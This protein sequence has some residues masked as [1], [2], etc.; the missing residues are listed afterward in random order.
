[1]SRIQFIIGQTQ[2]DKNILSKENSVK[3][4]QEYQNNTEVGNFF[5]MIIIAFICLIINKFRKIKINFDINLKISGRNK[6][7]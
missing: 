1:M 7:N 2:S 3:L 6:K 5:V 4:N